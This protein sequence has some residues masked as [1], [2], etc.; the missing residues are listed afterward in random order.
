MVLLAERIGEL[1]RGLHDVE[2]KLG[3]V[4][5]ARSEHIVGDLEVDRAETSYG[6]RLARNGGG[7]RA[8]ALEHHR[9][10]HMAVAGKR[11]DRRHVR[12]MGEID[13]ARRVRNIG[14]ERQRREDLARGL[15]RRLAF[16][17]RIWVLALEPRCQ[18]AKPMVRVEIPFDAA[19][20][21]RFRPERVGA[22]ATGRA[23]HDLAVGE[24]AFGAKDA[25]KLSFLTR[26]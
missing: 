2:A 5:H 22:F 4:L 6:H 18:L 20:A 1:P 10:N 3:A 8:A 9:A 21:G 25:G 7:N 12:V 13:H 16:G 15:L 19:N 26:D 14:A 11:Y 17:E 24:E 23:R